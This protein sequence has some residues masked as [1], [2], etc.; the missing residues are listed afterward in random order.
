MV[1]KNIIITTLITIIMYICMTYYYK[2][3]C[4]S[5]VNMLFGMPAECIYIQKIKKI[6]T[7]VWTSYTYK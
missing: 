5:L 4:V 1:K 2:N 7:L 3:Y 6:W